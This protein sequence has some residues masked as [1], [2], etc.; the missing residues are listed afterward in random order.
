MRLSDSSLS[1]SE[2]LI[3]TCHE[4]FPKVFLGELAAFGSQFGSRSSRWP[5]RRGFRRGHAV[6]ELRRAWPFFSSRFYGP[7][8]A[9]R[10]PLVDR[11]G[12]TVRDPEASHREILSAV[13]T[14]L[15]A[16]KINLAD[17]ALTIK[18][19]VHE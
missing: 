9:L 6:G 11:L 18:V 17:I 16:S 4:I 2:Q 3:G 8:P 10:Q 7:Y 19:Q 15:T 5:D 12:E 13:S 1:R 14:I